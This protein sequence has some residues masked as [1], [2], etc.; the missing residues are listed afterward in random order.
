MS[1]IPLPIMPS[2]HKMVKL[3]LK[4]LQ[5]MLE[6]S[7]VF[8]GWCPPKGHTFLNRLAPFSLQ[9]CL[10]MYDLLVTPSTKGLMCA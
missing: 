2:V 7:Y 8:S 6:G 3:P 1:G 9:I 10:S 4:I 5:K